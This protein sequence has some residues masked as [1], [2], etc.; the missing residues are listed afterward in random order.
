[1]ESKTLQ[2]YAQSDAFVRQLPIT[3]FAHK[4]A[5]GELTITCRN[6]HCPKCQG[7]YQRPTNAALIYIRTEWP[8]DVAPRQCGNADAEGCGEKPHSIARIFE[9][10]VKNENW[11]M[12]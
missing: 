12:P 9:K 10:S 8:L 1:M 2:I 7:A 6:R 3:E 4:A 11:P 5:N